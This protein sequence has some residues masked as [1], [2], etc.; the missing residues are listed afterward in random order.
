MEGIKNNIV[1]DWT[2]LFDPLEVDNSPWEEDPVDFKTFTESKDFLN[3]F[4]LSEVQYD[5]LNKLLGDNPKDIFDTSKRK[6]R[7]AALLWGK[8]SGKGTCAAIVATYVMYILLC[9]KNPHLYFG[10]ADQDTI[11]FVNVAMSMSQSGEL[12][13]RISS[14]FT[15]NKWFLEKYRILERGKVLLKSNTGATQTIKI[16]NG[17]IEFPKNLAMMC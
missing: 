9:L 1:V 7:E 8:G 3:H 13:K 6:F 4:A 10:V 15:T 5:E 11:H 16:G 17:T 12:F 2:T 14:R